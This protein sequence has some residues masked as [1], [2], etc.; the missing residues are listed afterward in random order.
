MSKN[1][2][3]DIIDQLSDELETC[4]PL[5]HPLQRMLPWLIIAPLYVFIIAVFV[6][7]LRDGWFDMLMHDFAFQIDIGLALFLFISSGAALGW[8]NLPDMRQDKWVL[9]FPSVALTLFLSNV[10][11][12]LI[13][14]DFS[15]PNWD[16]MC[17][18]HA[19]LM[20]VLPL[21]GLIYLIKE[22]CPFCHKRSA[23]LSSLSLSA[24][25]WIGLRMTSSIDHISNTFVIQFIPFI[26]LGIV[27]GL[28]SSKLFRW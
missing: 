14:A 24:L 23:L 19:A 12:R 4:K 22:G 16:L 17:T 6:I 13:T 27:L 5:A 18:P 26:V 3:K 2:D 21:G 11:Y 8:V 7:G 20:I 15:E 1:L 28:L 25:G 9:L 10:I